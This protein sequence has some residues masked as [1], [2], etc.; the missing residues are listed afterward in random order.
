M[1]TVSE[2]NAAS[3]DHF[4]ISERRTAEVSNKKLRNQMTHPLCD[5]R[6]LY[7][8]SLFK[9]AVLQVCNLTSHSLVEYWQRFGETCYIFQKIEGAGFSES[10]VYL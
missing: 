9:I 1:P 6:Y 2:C 10:L 3:S 5:T 8:A 7:R 4:W